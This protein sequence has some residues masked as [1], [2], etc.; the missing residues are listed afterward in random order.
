MSEFCQR[1]ITSRWFQP[2]IIFVILTT[3]ILIGLETYPQLNQVWGTWFRLIDRL[4]IG[5]FILE[6]LFKMGALGRRPWL[7]FRDPWN[8]FDFCIVAV[9]LLP[10]DSHSAAVLRM[11]R[12][13]RVLRLVTSLPRL[14]LLVG[15]LLKSLPSMGYVGL[16]LSMVFYV[17]AVMGTILFSANDPLH[18]GSLQSSLLTLFQTVTL[19]AWTDIMKLQ[20]YGSANFAMQGMNGT[21][22]Q[23]MG[24]P[25]AAI[26]YFVS[27]ILL[28]TMILLNLFIGVIM[29]GMQEAHR[30]AEMAEQK[31]RMNRLGQ[32]TPSEDIK[33]IER[34]LDHLK[35]A[36]QKIRWQAD[37]SSK[38]RQ[39]PPVDKPSSENR[40]ALNSEIKTSTLKSPAN[41]G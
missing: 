20:M 1:V 26:V 11:V 4:I 2:F 35:E 27:F 34:Q 31:S 10:F 39:D 21:A 13:L 41:H 12:I 7:Y 5:I 3:S 24:M 14:Q 8:F 38:K 29:N 17:Y 9:C 22:A 23:S 32:P 37:F 19:D 15:T 6:I 25:V 16:L 33:A 40:S 36:L 18:F 28:G 30:E